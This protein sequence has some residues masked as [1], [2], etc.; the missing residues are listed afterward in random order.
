MGMWFMANFLGN[1]LCG[2]IGTY[3]TRMPKTTFFFMLTGLAWTASILM[4]AVM[5]P[6]KKALGPE[7]NAGGDDPSKPLTEPD[8]TSDEHAIRTKS[9]IPAQADSAS[10][11]VSAA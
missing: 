10:A 9:G 4:L 8:G 7:K 5:V 11:K 1:Y 6:L 3:W 2:F